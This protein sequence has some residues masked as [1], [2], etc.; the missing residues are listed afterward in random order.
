MNPSNPFQDPSVLRAQSPATSDMNFSAM[1]PPAPVEPVG[2]A[3]Q[4]QPGVPRQN[5]MDEIGNQIKATNSQTI[6]KVMRLL[7][8]VLASATIAV[9]VMAWIFGQV[10]TF[11]RVIAGIYIIMFGSLLLAFELRT[12]KIDVVLRKNFGF[13][14]G[15]KTRTIFLV[16]I[17][18][19]PLSMGNFW[20]TIL[21]AVLLFLNAFFNYF[22]ISQ[23]PAFSTVPPVYDPNQPQAAYA[24]APNMNV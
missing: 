14:Y 3:Y 17:A 10:N 4:S 9:G 5:L 24:P 2:G 6:V 12:E 13:M 22:V 8:L 16:F 15:N 7:N 23:H 19:W 11:Q 1:S 18:I 20:L 21:D